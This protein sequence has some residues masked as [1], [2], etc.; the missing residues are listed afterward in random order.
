MFSHEYYSIL[1]FDHTNDKQEILKIIHG[2]KY[3][4]GGTAIGKALREMRLNEFNANSIR[5]GVEKIV[6]LFTDGQ[7]TDADQASFE[8]KKLKESNVKIFVVGIGPFIDQM[9][10]EDIASRP[11]KDFVHT[12]DSFDDM[13]TK[14]G[15][16][17]RKTCTVDEQIFVR[18]QE[19]K[20]I[21]A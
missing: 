6:I 19:G 1:K 9:E 18:E 11:S 2:I 5:P 10:L 12:F 20:C 3:L 7:S 13:F 16:L 15:I 4:G 17:S 14:G 21:Y 8:A